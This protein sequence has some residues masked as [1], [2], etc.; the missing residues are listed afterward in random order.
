MPISLKSMMLSVAPGK[1][2][3]VCGM[4]SSR[5]VRIARLDVSPCRRRSRRSQARARGVDLCDRVLD[6]AD[7]LLREIGVA[8]DVEVD[9]GRASRDWISTCSPARSLEPAP[10]RIWFARLESPLPT[11]SSAR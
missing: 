11:S 4:T 2:P 3:M 10:A 8:A 6:R 1:R 5:S 7:A 9:E